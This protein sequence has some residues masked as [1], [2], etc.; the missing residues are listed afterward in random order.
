[1]AVRVTHIDRARYGPIR[2][3][4][5]VGQQRMTDQ[6]DAADFA[7]TRAEPRSHWPG[8][9]LVVCLRQASIQTPS[10]KTGV[11]GGWLISESLR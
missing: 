2:H 3:N 4:R 11:S 10:M 6:Q 5:G 8:G 9:N 1:M 7:V